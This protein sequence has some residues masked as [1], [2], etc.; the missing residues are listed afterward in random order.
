[1]AQDIKNSKQPHISNENNILEKHEAKNKNHQYKFPSMEVNSP[2][3]TINTEAPTTQADLYLSELS[4][5]DS[6][7]SQ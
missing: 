3:T 7:P 2:K 6:V 5:T 4:L 1:M